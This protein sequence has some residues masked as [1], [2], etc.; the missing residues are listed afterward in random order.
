VRRQPLA[1]NDTLIAVIQPA[2]DDDHADIGSALMA[3]W[4]RGLLGDSSDYYQFA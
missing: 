1:E 4:P 3:G 2:T